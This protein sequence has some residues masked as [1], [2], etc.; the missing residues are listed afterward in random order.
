MPVCCE[1]W[2]N[3]NNAFAV[4]AVLGTPCTLASILFAVV[5]FGIA[6]RDAIRPPLLRVTPTTLLLPNAAR[7]Q[8]LEKD[9]RGNP[10]QDGPHTHP[11]EIPFTAIRWIRREAGT[12]P[13]NDK[14]MIVHD[15]S[16]VTLELQQSLMRTAD[17]D[18]LETVLRVAVPEAFTALPVPPSPRP[19]DGV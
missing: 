8:P 2:R 1:Q 16:T 6:V 18:E 19:P 7:G 4:L 13:G 17:F 5:A 14:L 15:L 10:K 3:G 12:N 11:E 9:A